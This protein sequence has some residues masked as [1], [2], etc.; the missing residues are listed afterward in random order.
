LWQRQGRVQEAHT[1]LA[2][3]VGWFTEG[4]E[5]LDLQEAQTLLVESS[6]S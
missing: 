3:V 4:F 1:L 6:D 2:G 5:T